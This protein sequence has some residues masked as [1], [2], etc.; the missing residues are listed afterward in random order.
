MTDTMKTPDARLDAALAAMREPPAVDPDTVARVAARA[1]LANEPRVR[2][3]TWTLRAAA[4]VAV[5]ALGAAAL[6]ANQSV[7]DPEPD[8]AVASVA[9]AA[10]VARVVNITPVIATGARPIVFELNAPNAQSV[11]VLGDFNQWSRDVNSMERGTDGRWRLTTML[12]P[13][14]YVYAY[15]VD[16][17]R[18]QRDPVRDAIEDRDFGVTGS[19]LVVGEAP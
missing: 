18:F 17:R 13:G 7:M 2:A 14:R 15:L 1:V 9:P 5:V 16:G 8:R 12:P 4:A 3:N 11:Q 19:E 6:R 10:E